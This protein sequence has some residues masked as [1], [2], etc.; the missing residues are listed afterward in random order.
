ML[1]GRAATGRCGRRARLC[2]PQC[3]EFFGAHW[4]R[5]EELEALRAVLLRLLTELQAQ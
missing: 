4:L 1:A 5:P 2:G 3:F